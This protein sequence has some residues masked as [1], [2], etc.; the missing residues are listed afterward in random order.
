MGSLKREFQSYRRKGRRGRSAAWVLE[1]KGVKKYNPSGRLVT[2]SKAQVCNM[3]SNGLLCELLLWNFSPDKDV[4]LK[5]VGP[6]IFYSALS[7]H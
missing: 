2:I 5:V 3:V 1:I 6:L 4:R 7:F